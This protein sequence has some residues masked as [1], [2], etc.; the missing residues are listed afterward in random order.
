MRTT[1]D[2][3]IT[4]LTAGPLTVG[5]GSGERLSAP[6]V[7]VHPI[8]DTLGGTLAAAWGEA[9]SGV[10]VTCVG[11]SRKQAEWLA[12]RVTA[13]LLAATDTLGHVEVLTSGPVT[14]DD[15]TGAPSLFL[16]YPRFRIH[17]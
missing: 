1:T 11:E 14:R 15:G 10:Q 6:Y 12:E 4:A 17:T 13:L 16:A 3:V 5:D 9:Q 8:G 2:A 7:V